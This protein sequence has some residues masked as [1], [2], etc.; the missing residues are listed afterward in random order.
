MR[1]N[2][3]GSKVIATRIREC[4]KNSLRELM[5]C[6]FKNNLYYKHKGGIVKHYPIFQSVSR[7]HN[8]H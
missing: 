4:L 6:A 8:I 2:L 7:P 5:R 3:K 1:M